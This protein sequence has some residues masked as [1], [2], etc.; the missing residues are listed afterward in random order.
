ML[1]I[2]LGV[3]GGFIGWMIAFIGVEKIISALWPA[4][5]VNQKA[6]EEAV[7]NGAGASG[8]TADTTMLLTQLVFGTAVSVMAGALAAFIAGENSKAPLIAGCLLLLMGVAKAVMS[9]HYVP[10]WY[11]VVFTAMLLPMVIVG[12]KLIN[13]A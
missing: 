4:F 8:F 1:R 3:I 10:I 5:G 13:P 6:F 12:G 11:H 2:V 7:K 9:W